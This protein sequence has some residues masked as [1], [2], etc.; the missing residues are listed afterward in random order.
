MS[1]KFYIIPLAIVGLGVW[2]LLK[3]EPQK[4]EHVTV[5]IAHSPDAADEWCYEGSRNRQNWHC[6]VREFTV[7][8]G[9]FEGVSSAN[10]NIQVE[11]WDKSDV[12]VRAKIEGRAGSYDAA[13][14]LVSAVTLTT[15]EDM[16]KASGPRQGRGSNWSVSY[17]A[18]VP[19]KSDLT[20]SATNGNV[21]VTEVMGDLNARSTNGNVQLRQVGG[22]V[23]GGTTNGNVKIELAGDAW[24]GEGVD[25]RTTNGSIELNIPADYNGVLE[26]A[27]VNGSINVDFPVTVTGKISKKLHAVLGDGGA[28]IKAATTNGSVRIRKQ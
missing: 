11:G 9:S 15:T 21:T 26:A 2:L 17:R 7:P 16:L 12:F 22:D 6:E 3:P 23:S 20:V 13:R 1:P 27:T 8:A 14:E 5:S 25:V 28:V 10:G 24:V 18:M 4:H 19:A